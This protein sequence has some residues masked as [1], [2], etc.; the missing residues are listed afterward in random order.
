MRKHI[1]P[2]YVL[3]VFIGQ[4][5]FSQEFSFSKRRSLTQGE[6]YAEDISAAWSGTQWGVFYCV[7]EGGLDFLRLN[8]KGKILSKSTIFQGKL[9]VGNYTYDNV[10]SCWGGGGWGI[11]VTRSKWMESKD[12]D[13]LVGENDNLFYCLDDQAQIVGDGLRLNGRM[14]GAIIWLGDFYLVYYSDPYAWI[15]KVAKV[16]LNGKPIGSPKTIMTLNVGDSISVEDAIVTQN[17]IIVLYH[18]RNYSSGE[19]YSGMVNVDLNNKMIKKPMIFQTVG[20]PFHA[21]RIRWTGN[22]YAITGELIKASSDQEFAALGV[23]DVNGK[24]KQI[25]K[26]IADMAEKIYDVLDIGIAFDGNWIY[27][28]Y[29]FERQD[30]CSLWGRTEDGKYERGEYFFFKYAIYFAGCVVDINNMSGLFL[31]NKQGINNLVAGK[32]YYQTFDLPHTGKPN[33]MILEGK[34]YKIGKKKYAVLVWRIDGANKVVIK[35][36]GKTETMPPAGWL[37]WPVNKGGVAM[38]IKAKNSEG[39]IN[40]KYKIK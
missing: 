24:W 13:G 4:F 22:N 34:M 35:G 26:T 10:I 3:L 18:V 28:F 37:A 32:A 11:T 15:L 21:K 17:G 27:Q 14:G 40:S 16:D 33:P 29:N 9:E 12:S 20:Y 38:R 23:S 31:I 25:P 1:I 5:M 8:Q 30:R 36:A 19:R 2:M 7:R 39:S 6:N